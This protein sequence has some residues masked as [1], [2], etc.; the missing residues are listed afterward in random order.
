MAVKAAKIPDLLRGVNSW[1]ARRAK[2]LVEKPH[3][4]VAR[5]ED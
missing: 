5:D 1:S 3:A 2:D 4:A